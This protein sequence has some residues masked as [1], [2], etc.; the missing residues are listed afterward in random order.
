MSR[1]LAIARQIARGEPVEDP[2]I[3]IVCSDP[4]TCGPGNS[5]PEELKTEPV[6]PV[7]LAPK[8]TSNES[9]KNSKS[10]GGF[11][12]SQSPDADPPAEPP[13]AMA[14]EHQ[15]T[16]DEIDRVVA[17]VRHKVA[18]RPSAVRWAHYTTRIIGLALPAI[19]RLRLVELVKM[20]EYDD[21]KAVRLHQSH[22]RLSTMQIA[23]TATIPILIPLGMHQASEAI[24]DSIHYTATFLSFMSMVFEVIMRISKYSE[25]AYH[26][27]K[28]N[29][30]VERELQHF[31]AGSGT[32]EDYKGSHEAA[33]PTFSS[34]QTELAF[35]RDTK[36]INLHR[37][38]NV[39]E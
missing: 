4:I 12:S 7:A 10:S 22:Q 36:T 39:H 11:C 32:Y 2:M 6:R 9:T 5:T 24:G 30:A 15:P 28:A 23:M 21:S 3:E 17:E 27:S 18:A 26:M 19:D 38:P 29:A 13:L 35:T 31:L 1:T 14:A 37:P 33:L 20:M 16:L 34:R 8:S 25:Q